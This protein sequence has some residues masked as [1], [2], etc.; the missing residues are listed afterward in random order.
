M[1][2]MDGFEATGAIREREKVSGEHLL[3][4]AMTAHAMQG[5]R[6]RCIQAGMDDYITKPVRRENL[7]AT[8]TRWLSRLPDPAEADN[9]NRWPV[10]DEEILAQ[11]VEL[12]A[13]GQAGLIAEVARLFTEQAPMVLTAIRSAIETGDAQALRARLHMLRG[14]ASS[15]GARSLA[16]ACR[17]WEERAGALTP[18]IG[19]E[20][21]GQLTTEYERVKLKLQEWEGA[22]AARIG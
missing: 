12:E 18:V 16:E 1:P 20:T 15:I 19:R 7:E 5:D 4:V 17:G 6:E 8:L 14:T 21:I 9:G 2:E 11:L 10:L 13:E 22:R 3:I